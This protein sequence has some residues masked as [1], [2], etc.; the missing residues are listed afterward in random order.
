MFIFAAALSFLAR[1]STAGP[2]P[3]SALWADLAAA[4]PGPARAAL[5]SRLLLG[6][7]YVRSPLGEGKTPDAD[8][9][10]RLDAFDCVTF[11]ETAIALGHA[12]SA[13][14]ARALLDDVRY[15]GPADFQHRN[16]Y[17]EAQW[18]PANARKGWVEEVTERVAGA[19]AVPFRVRLDEEGWRAAERA[20]NVLADL[21]P[22]RRPR[23][24]WAYSLVPLARLVAL[25]PRIP[26]GTILLVVR[27]ERRARPYRVT[28]LGLV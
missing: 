23:G 4:A 7:P 20:G 3:E 26:E 24:A 16:H 12:A 28:H 13:A 10:F 5:A 22:G 14:E 21:D 17:L 15:D 9:R 2:T 18:L 27:E 1:A 19:W 25:A 8:P 11:V 6:A